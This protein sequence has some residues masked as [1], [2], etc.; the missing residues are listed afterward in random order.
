MAKIITITESNLKTIIKHIVKEQLE[1]SKM[2]PISWVKS[3]VNKVQKFFDA[4]DIVENTGKRIYNSGAIDV[5]SYPYRAM[6][7][8]EDA[9]SSH[10][11]ISYH[12]DTFYPK[13]SG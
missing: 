11:R 5:K 10:Y 4:M 6:K 13:D 9:F 2:N 1:L 3:N 7:D 12:S 8:K